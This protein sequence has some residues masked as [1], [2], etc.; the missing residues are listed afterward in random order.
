MPGTGKS[1]EGFPLVL[2]GRMIDRAAA[3]LRC[4]CNSEPPQPTTR[5]PSAHLVLS[6]QNGLRL[7]VQGYRSR[8]GH[9][10][11]QPFLSLQETWILTY[12]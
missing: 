10:G 11:R 4:I 12:G 7:L 2:T 3:V 1:H 9:A 5:K 6:Y 8:K